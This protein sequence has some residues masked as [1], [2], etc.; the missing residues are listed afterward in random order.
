MFQLFLTA[1]ANNLRNKFR[2]E[3]KFRTRSPSRDAETDNQRIV[4]ISASIE[5]A[6]AASVQEMSSLKTRLDDAIVR[7]SIVAGN[8]DDE[9]LTR[10]P[11]ANAYLD[12]LDTEIANAER[13]ITELAD[14]LSHF[15]FFRAVMMTR[16]P[17][18][19]SAL[20]PET[21]KT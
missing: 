1:R 18:F 10:D 11:S 14:S 2:P 7:A 12:E 21:T 6:I 8:G 5:G 20:N 15:R 4:S 19:K 17:N 16:F 9:Y 13:R 3:S